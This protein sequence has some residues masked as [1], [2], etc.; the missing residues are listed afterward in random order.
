MSE[1]LR[2]FRDRLVGLVVG[3]V[4]LARRVVAAVL[5]GA[6]AV[7]ELEIERLLAALAYK[8]FGEVGIA[9]FAGGLGEFDECHFGDFVPG[10]AVQLAVGGAES[11]IDVISET[12]GRVKQ[13]AFAGGL[14]VGDRAFGQVAEAVQLMVVL[15]PLS[16]CA[17]QTIS[18]A[19]SAVASRSASGWWV[20]E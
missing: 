7:L 20:S 17:A 4:L 2:L 11:G 12:A 3:V 19:V 5:P 1:G 10:I 13:L 9:L 18:M 16:S 14:I 8:V 15:Q 6:A